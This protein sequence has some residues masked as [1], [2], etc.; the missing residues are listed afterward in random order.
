MSL[1]YERRKKRREEDRVEKRRKEKTQQERRRRAGGP[2][3]R[4]LLVKKPPEPPYGDENEPTFGS[5][6]AHSRVYVKTLEDTGVCLLLR[7]KPSRGDCLEDDAEKHCVVTHCPL[8]IDR[9]PHDSRVITASVQD[10]FGMRAQH[11]SMRNS[12]KRCW[13]D[14]GKKHGPGRI[15]CCS[16]RNPISTVKPKRDSGVQQKRRKHLQSRDFLQFS[17]HLHNVLHRVRRLLLVAVGFFSLSL[18]VSKMADPRRCANVL[19]KRLAQSSCWKATFI[20]DHLERHHLP[21][22]EQSRFFL[23]HG[24][25]HCM[26]CKNVSSVTAPIAFFRSLSLCGN[27]RYRV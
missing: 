5:G 15:G 2:E 26:E 17:F 8:R 6:S 1:G 19:V 3:T 9:Q 21:T 25:Q 18:D 20:P 16:E 14:V 12:R 11:C 10:S 22:L 7:C 13:S 4:Q 23:P 27:D 24:G